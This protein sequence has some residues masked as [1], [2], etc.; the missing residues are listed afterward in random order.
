[1]TAARDERLFLTE[2]LDAIER[3]LA[4]TGD[5]REAFFQTPMIQDAVVRNLAIIGEATR[6][7]SETTKD[8][9]S[10]IPWRD[11]S[12]MRNKIIHHYFRVDLDVV[13]NV[14]AEDLR[15]LRDRIRTLLAP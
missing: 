1:M 10:E 11:M 3:V 15:P 2:I 6:G 13:W 9:H 12:D 5:G 14:V 8:V 4:Y 7:V